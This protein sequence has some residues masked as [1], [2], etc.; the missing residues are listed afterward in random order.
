[1]LKLHK[2]IGLHPHRMHFDKKSF[3]IVGLVKNHG[4]SD[5]SVPQFVHL[6]RD[7]QAVYYGKLHRLRPG[8]SLNVAY[9]C[10][11]LDQWLARLMTKAGA[12]DVLRNVKQVA[13]VPR[14]FQERVAHTAAH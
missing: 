9:E 5:Q 11:H 13:K 14:H 7:G 6:R 4:R 2:H 3:H 12:K 10:E 1:M 8:Q